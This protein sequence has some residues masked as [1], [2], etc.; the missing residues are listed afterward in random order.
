MR[1]VRTLLVG[2]PALRDTMRG[3]LAEPGLVLVVAEVDSLAEAGLALAGGR[4]ELLLVAHTGELPPTLRSIEAL[5]GEEPGAGAIL[6]GAPLD[7]R[8]LS[9][10]MQA[11]VRE[12]LASTEAAALRAAVQ[13]AATFFARLHGISHQASGPR[14]QQGELVV[15]HAPK[16][17]AGKSTLAVNLAVAL[18]LES[19][20]R[21]ALVDISPQF[22]VIDLLLNLRPALH[23]SDLARLGGTIDAETIDQALVRHESGLEVLASAPDP[24]EGELIE[25]ELVERV[26]TDLRARRAHVV[27]DTPP[28]LS[29]A[30]VRAMELADR[31]LVP[32]FPDL[33]SLRHVQ[34][35]LKLWG[36]LG[37]D[38]AKVEL[39]G[40]AQPSEVDAAA[41]ARVL[42][43]PLDARLPYAPEAAIAAINAGRPMVMDPGPFAK[44]LRAQVRARLGL[45]APAPTRPLAM[46]GAL[47]RLLR[48]SD[49][50]AQPTQA[51]T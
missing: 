8:E 5:L 21:C 48:R 17:G 27:V 14:A 44:A 29:E 51:R 6:V 3:A 41:I 49:V 19:T 13:R 45:T 28:T 11:G 16:G 47:T 46:V 4:G 10:A 50:P 30:L 34:Q 36:A 18:A 40:W 26:L 42:A 1:P 15:V 24:E 12:V 39:V 9:L 38:L 43:R 22:G 33:A 2:P 35:S 25:R 20:E 37:I 32:F 31:I 7:A 23:L